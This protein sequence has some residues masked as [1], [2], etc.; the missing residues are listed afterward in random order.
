VGTAF[1]GTSTA[2]VRDVSFTSELVNMTKLD[3]GPGG[4]QGGQRQPVFTS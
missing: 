2:A 3:P 4:R 1:A